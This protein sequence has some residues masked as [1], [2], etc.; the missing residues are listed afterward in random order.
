MGFFFIENEMLENLKNKKII[1][2]FT[3]TCFI[4]EHKIII[5]DMRYRIINY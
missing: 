4:F 2:I 5:I 1:K 3:N